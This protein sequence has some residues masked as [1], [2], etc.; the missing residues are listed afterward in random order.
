MLLRSLRLIFLLIIIISLGGC[1]Q[2][3]R[4]A[5]QLSLARQIKN[6]I[7]SYSSI[8]SNYYLKQL[9][10]I[11]AQT[12]PRKKIDLI[13]QFNR[14]TTTQGLFTQSYLNEVLAGAY[15]QLYR[16]NEKN[17]YENSILHYKKALD[18]IS[19][20]NYPFKWAILNNNLS[21][22]Y[23]EYSSK[24][25]KDYIDKAAIHAL[26]ALKI[27]KRNEFPEMWADAQ[28][29]LAKAFLE[30][31]RLK[32]NKEDKT[33]YTELAA[34]SFQEIIHARTIETDPDRYI[35]IVEQ[36]STAEIILDRYSNALFYIGKALEINESQLQLHTNSNIK[37]KLELIGQVQNIFA[38]A[39]WA[40]VK[41]NQLEKAIGYMEWGK[42]RLLRSNLVLTEES[43]INLAGI[44]QSQNIYTWLTSLSPNSTVI[45]PIFSKFG[46]V[47]FILPSHTQ[48]F[49]KINYLVLEDFTKEDLERL[50]RGEDPLEWG[51][52]LKTYYD[53]INAPK[54]ESKKKIWEQQLEHTLTEVQNHLIK[55][56]LSRLSELGIPNGS[57]L[58]WLSDSDSNLLPIHATMA[59]GK[60]LLT[61]YIFHYFPSLYSAFIIEQQE[62]Q[63]YREDINDHL[64]SVITPETPKEYLHFA[65]IEGDEINRFFSSRHQLY[66][67]E[68][69]I[70]RFIEKLRSGPKPSYLH[71][72][73]H[74][75][76]FLQ[77]PD[78][79]G[80]EF[81]NDKLLTIN[82]IHSKS[83]LFKN[84][85]LAVLSACETG[86][87]D[88]ITTNNE[89][90]GLSTAFLQA[91][92]GG[93]I[94]T[95][96]R[97]ND[98]S[99]ALLMLKFYQFHREQN[100]EPAIALAE[101]Q[102]WLRSASNEEVKK[103]LSQI[104]TELSN[105]N[106]E[107][108]NQNTGKILF[109]NKSNGSE[110][111]RIADTIALTKIR[112][113]K[114]KLNVDNAPAIPYENPY[115]WAGFV[116]SGI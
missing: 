80:I 105:K 52:Y 115:Y 29:N 27:F 54:N 65:R 51:G 73:T 21:G 100:F 46:T 110:K 81:A 77:N 90:M 12:D 64:L 57:R 88:F 76:Y 116:Y 92:V 1:F 11:N 94:S 85:R 111:R 69:T 9:D 108:L 26:N 49:N 25:K 59:N 44:P 87:S 37:E 97:V 53:R 63:Y 89:A 66:D 72:A 109:T 93:V 35:A 19:E 2:P 96:W 112:N 28:F 7:Q 78:E 13:H 71:F 68:A 103:L 106:N 86:M 43:S 95:L 22:V 62:K 48:K 83:N 17:D 70:E 40:A 47:T 114:R 34:A 18:V 14:L 99:T 82:D 23:L 10:L 50:T 38:N 32:N 91:G 84:T 104:D 113:L 107:W 61:K 36:L 16:I 31:A 75:I 98:E 58:Y 102:N 101:A 55:P 41:L 42:A 60:P 4:T 24:N 30:R 5:E 67:S 3:V 33:R 79:S 45:S 20:E 6:E 74:G 15:R 56:V 8:N 39:V